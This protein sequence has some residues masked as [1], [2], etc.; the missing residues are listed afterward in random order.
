MLALPALA[1]A[2]KQWPNVAITLVGREDVGR[3]ALAAGLVDRT[4][5]Y[6]DASWSRLFI[7]SS[8]SAPEAEYA[9]DNLCQVIR[10]SA[11]LAWLHDEDGLVERN[12]SRLGAETTV[13]APGRPDPLMV[14]HMAV[15]LAR[16][17][18]ALGLQ[19]RLSYGV[20]AALVS[21]FLAATENSV[22]LGYIRQ[23]RQ[24]L[25][26]PDRPVVAF[27]AGSGGSA[28]RWP[29]ELFARL[30]ESCVARGYVPLLITGPQ[31]EDCTKA[32]MAA[33][34]EVA[35][36]VL[37]AARD[38]SLCQLIGVLSQCA[39][40]VGNDSGMT[41]LAALSGVPTLALFGPTDPAYWAPLG[42]QVSI[43]RPCC[44][45]K[46]RGITLEAAWDA[47]HNLL[48]GTRQQSLPGST[49]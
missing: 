33:C 38:L 27:H 18:E 35:R 41:H 45:D 17:L 11:V 3:L 13:F 23:T 43:I 31:D 24:T 15:T 16:G 44:T 46:M 14:E 19:P 42:R 7:D 47:L 30:I 4:E 37:H 40:Y 32:V 29:P 25:E 20:L 21:D 6:G 36:R 1:L 5:V 49:S 39:A 28:K 26:V 10:G 8:S 12:L 48:T 34:S 22:D 9:R 2:R